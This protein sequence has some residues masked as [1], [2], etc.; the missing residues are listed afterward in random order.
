M[1][2][3]NYHSGEVPC[4][5]RDLHKPN[6]EKC[7]PKAVM[8][9]QAVTK[10]SNCFCRLNR[11]VELFIDQSNDTHAFMVSTPRE[12]PSNQGKFAMNMLRLIR[13]VRRGMSWA[14]CC[15][16][17]NTELRNVEKQ[18]MSTDKLLHE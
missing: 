1:L 4:M 12:V 15:N 5:G 6:L 7:N 10:L 17:L 16:I 14:E 2:C 13:S 8:Q 3:D 11:T 18:M 9:S